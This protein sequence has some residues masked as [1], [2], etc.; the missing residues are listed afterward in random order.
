MHLDIKKMC[1]KSNK[2]GSI[3]YITFVSIDGPHKLT[4]KSQNIPK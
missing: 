3:I 4:P 1:P 2:E